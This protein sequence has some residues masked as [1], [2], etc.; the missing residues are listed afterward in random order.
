MDD[1]VTLLKVVGSRVFPLFERSAAMVTAG[2]EDVLGGNPPYYFLFTRVD[3]NRF[4]AL[5]RESTAG[6]RAA[7]ASFY[8]FLGRPF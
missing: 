8:V 5:A 1:N 2:W 3:F 4:A 6:E 7:Y